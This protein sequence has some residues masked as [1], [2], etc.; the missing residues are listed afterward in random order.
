MSQTMISKISDSIARGEYRTD[1]KFKKLISLKF[2]KKR[3]QVYIP[4]R[5]SQEIR[6]L[7][8]EIAEEYS[9]DLKSHTLK[10]FRLHKSLISLVKA[11]ALRDG[12]KIVMKRDIERIRYLSQWMNLKMN[13][14]K[15]SYPFSYHT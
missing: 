5:Y 8:L 3:V 10:G 9:E 1:K 15:M 12:R 13:K 2:P 7:A 6:D 14:L 11:S 4:K